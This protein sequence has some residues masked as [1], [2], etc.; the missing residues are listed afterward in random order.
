MNQPHDPAGFNH[1]GH[2][3]RA[4]G[5]QADGLPDGGVEGDRHGGVE[6]GMG[7]FDLPDGMGDHI[8]RDVLGEDR[9][10]AAA[11]HGLGHPPA[12]DGGH[13][14]RDQRQR[15]RQAVGGGEVDVQPGGDIGA[16]RHHENVGIGEVR[17]GP[18]IQ[19]THT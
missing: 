10:P 13:V 11:R 3:V 15:C 1:D 5:H 16:V 19:E 6:D 2:P 7:L 17:G 9:E 18:L 14:R 8:G 4:F 12:G